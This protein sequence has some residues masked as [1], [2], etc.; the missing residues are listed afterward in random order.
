[1]QRKNNVK[2][3]CLTHITLPIMVIAQTKYLERQ[4]SNILSAVNEFGFPSKNQYDED[5]EVSMENKF[6]LLEVERHKN[7]PEFDTSPPKNFKKLRHFPSL[8][9]K[10]RG[11]EK[12][13]LPFQFPFYSASVSSVYITTEGFLS[14]GTI[15]HGDMHQYSYLA[16]LMAD[17]I[18]SNKTGKIL[19][20][21]SN[22]HVTFEWKNMILEADQR[23]GSFTF[24]CILYR[25]GQIEFY[26]EK[27]PFGNN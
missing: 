9:N 6:Y 7:T 24:S 13:N 17:F 5:M 20:T 18:P 8:I 22:D 2:L 14:M 11:A 12:V 26:Y 1:M 10:G 25:N 4:P 15:L 16:P 27:F 3:F 19:M 21:A 23:L